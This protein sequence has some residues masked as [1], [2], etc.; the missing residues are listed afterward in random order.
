MVPD[1]SAAPGPA[2]LR[3]EVAVLLAGIALAVACSSA[4]GLLP[5][6]PTTAGQ[7]GQG[8]LRFAAVWLP[9]GVAAVSVHGRPRRRDLVGL[10][11]GLR[12]AVAALGIV[13]VPRTVQSLLAGLDDVSGSGPTL[14]PTVSQTGQEAAITL[15]VAALVLLVVGPVVHAV[16]FQAVLQPRLTKLTAGAPEVS[17]RAGTVGAVASA[18]LATAVLPLTL[19]SMLTGRTAYEIV[20]ELGTT[21]VIVSLAGGLRVLFGRSGGVVLVYALL[22]LTASAGAAAVIVG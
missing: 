13:L 4:V 20:L 17:A 2:R 8:I 16:V 1:A 19:T 21:L 7:L 18:A 22:T 11:F 12:E 6:T 10:R 9:L 3:R 14:V 5:S 15:G